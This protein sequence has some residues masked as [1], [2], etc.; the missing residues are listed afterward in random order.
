MKETMFNPVPLKAVPD[1]QAIVNHVRKNGFM[2]LDM[3]T[4]YATLY[5]SVN[6]KGLGV[7]KVLDAITMKQIG[8]RVQPLRKRAS[9]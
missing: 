9:D 6:A 5:P 2:L 1:Y 3:N 8:W 7:V 4:N